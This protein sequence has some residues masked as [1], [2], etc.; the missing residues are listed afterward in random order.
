MIE[1]YHTF[2]YEP[3]FNL[4]VFF[5]NVLPG[6]DIGIAIIALTILIKLILFPLGLQSIRSQKALQN[7][8]PKMEELK[9]KYKDNKE[10]LSV[11][12]MSLYKSEKVNPFSSC[13]PILVQFPFLIAV[14][15]VFRSGLSNSN[16]DLLY[17]F[18]SNP[19][20]IDPYFFG[21]LDLGQPQIALA[22]LAGA[23]QFWQA[24]MLQT[25]KPPKTKEGKVLP[26]AKDETAMTIMN[27]QMVYFMPLITVVIGATLPGGLALY[28][29]ITTF[30]MAL[31]QLYFFR[32]D[33]GKGEGEK[34][35][36]VKAV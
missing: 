19:G 26:G 30:L 27:K 25:K 13:L 16:F 21:W 17:P 22:I 20:V 34:P 4:L 11:E 18:V 10:K 9:K 32:K 3:L 12:M 29:L 31:Q 36:A 15:Q 33:K 5:Y 6:H 28:W 8:Q 35:E 7:L 24:K 1:I 23:A 2:L 14:Y